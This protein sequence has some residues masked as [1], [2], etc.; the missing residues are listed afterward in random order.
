MLQTAFASRRAQLLALEQQAVAE[1][2]EIQ[3]REEWQAVLQMQVRGK[4]EVAAG[5]L[6]E[7]FTMLKNSWEQLH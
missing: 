1:M 7:G 4:R 2:P 6:A 3:A 5:R